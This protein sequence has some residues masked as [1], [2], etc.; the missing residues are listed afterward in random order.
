M[1]ID[2]NQNFLPPLFASPTL[3]QLGGGEASRVGRRNE[4]Q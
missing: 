2:E 3:N 4:L 1:E